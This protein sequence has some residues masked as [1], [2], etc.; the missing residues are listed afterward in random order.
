VVSGVI[1]GGQGGAIA[2]SEMF[3]GGQKYHFAPPQIIHI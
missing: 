3:V 2:P 1:A